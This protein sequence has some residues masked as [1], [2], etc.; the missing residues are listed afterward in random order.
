MTTTP[1]KTRS[2][3]GQAWDRFA[4]RCNSLSR[5]ALAWGGLALAGVI[6]LSVNLISSIELRDWQAD[7]TEE[8]LFTISDGAREVLRKIEEPI[9]VRL[10]FSKRLGEAS[11]VYARYF[12][13]VQRMIERFGDIAGG[14]LEISYIDPEA[15]SQEED[16]AVAA[17][18]RK[19]AFNAEGEVGYFGLSAT[20][21][22]DNQETVPFF[23]LDRESFLEYDLAK[24]VHNLA[25]PK[26]RVVGVITGLPIGG[27][28]N[29]TTGQTMPPWAIM[30]QIGELFDIRMLDQKVKTIPP[31]IDVLLVVQPTDLTPEATYA[32]DQFALAGGRSLVLVDPVSEVSQFTNVGADKKGLEEIAKVL[33]AWGIEFDR[34]AVAADIAHARRVRFGQGGETVT[35]YV[36]WLGLD[37]ASMAKEDVLA[38]GVETLNFASA[39]ILKPKK[40]AK[41]SIT[42]IVST[43]PQ[44]MQIGIT[45]V[46][47]RADP[48]KL[49]QNYKPGGTP[50]MLMARVSGEAKSAFPD[51]PPKDGAASKPAEASEPAKD[52][53][54]EAKPTHR[55]SGNINAIVVADTDL[56]ADPFWTEPREML[57]QRVMVPN[58]QNA[59]LI[60]GALENLSGSESLIALRGRGVANRPFTKVEDLRRAAERRFRESEQKLTQRLTELQGEIAKLESS[61]DGALVLAANDAETAAK[62]RAEML[63]TRRELRDVKLALRRDIDRLDGWL[64]FANIALVPLLIG[65]GGLMWSMRRGKRDKRKTGDAGSEKQ[66]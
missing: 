46:G 22:T 33:E 1:K 41:T 53:K 7:L 65:A 38:A 52:E 11:P 40:D 10:Y 23:Y 30:T 8:R 50:F 60:I 61:N 28:Q 5:P 17:G 47:V 37:A 20:N 31:D 54:G 62:V 3:I 59:A 24:L 13:R 25:N 27:A 42:P 14:K 51:G 9:S 55:A 15:F 57:G 36:G 63:Q 6:L 66:P 44:A 32:I 29:E 64:K 2:R 39:G 26:K 18:L 45:D 48:A 34:K 4:A 16:A 49:L 58:A 35:A 21:S 43:S 56:M 12:N 19:V